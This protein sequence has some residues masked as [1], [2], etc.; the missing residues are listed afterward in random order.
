V[1]PESPPSNRVFFVDGPSG[2][3]E[4]TTDVEAL[5]DVLIE[6]RDDE[7]RQTPNLRGRGGYSGGG[8]DTLQITRLRQDQAEPKARRRQPKNGLRSTTALARN[9]CGLHT[10]LDARISIGNREWGQRARAG[11]LDRGRAHGSI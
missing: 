2:S 3:R 4:L 1:L 6:E 7:E 11:S 5:V 10:E 9:S 8:R